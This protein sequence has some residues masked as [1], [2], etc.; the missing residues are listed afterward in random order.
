VAGQLQRSKK[1]QQ[2][3]GLNENHN[4]DMKAIF[5]SAAAMASRRE[6]PFQDFYLE[7]LTKGMKPAMA[8]LTLARKIAA[9]TLILW[10]KGA[11]F[12]AEQLKPQAA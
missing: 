1:P 2:L 12:D 4:H 9:I 11:H 10:K 6:G 5:K 7:L 3:R 8:R